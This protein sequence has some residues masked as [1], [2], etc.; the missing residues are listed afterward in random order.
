MALDS[1][2]PRLNDWIT[3]PEAAEV[4]GISKQAVH[5]MASAGDIK[6]IHLIGNRPVYVVAEAEI[7]ALATRRAE[8]AETRAILVATRDA[9]REARRARRDLA[10]SALVAS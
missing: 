5:K 2:A 7:R 4:L 6:T 3:L 8:I 9:R 10:E 1:E